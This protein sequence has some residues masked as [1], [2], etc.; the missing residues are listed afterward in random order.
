M[1][2]HNVRLIYARE[3]RDQLRDRRTLF[4]IAVLPLLLY[5]LLGMSV[6]QLSQF[7]RTSEPHVVI[8]G[9]E[10]IT[11]QNG[12]PALFKE[13]RFAPDLFDDPTDAERFVLDFEG[14]R[15]GA[16]EGSE[17]PT[18]VAQLDRTQRRLE[19]GEVDVALYFPA[20]FGRRLRE[21]HSAVESSGQPADGRSQASGRLAPNVN[22][23][24][25]PEILYNS[26]REKSRVAHSQVEQ[27]LDTWKSQIVR[28]NLLASRVPANIARPFELRPRDVAGRPEQQARVWSKILPFVLFIWALTGA[29]YPAVDLCAGEKERGTL[30]TLL[31]SP[32]LRGEI[33]WGKLLTVMTF[34]AATALLNLMSLGFTAR[35]VITQLRLIPTMGDMTAG[36]DLPPLA[37]TLWLLVALV[38][39]SALFSALC[40]ASAAFARSTKEGQYYLMP[41]LLVTMPLMMLPMAPGAE[42]NLGNSLIPV[43]GVVLLLKSLVQGNYT[44][45]LR[46]ALPVC[47]VTLACC[48]FAIRWAVYQ[49]NQETV[50]FRES[51]RF[52]LRRWVVHLVRDRQPTPSLAEA[53]FCVAIIYVV[54]FFVRLAV[55]SHMPASPEFSYL[56]LVLFISVVVCIALPA[57]LMTVILTGRPM[58]TL[59]L[60]RVPRPTA[61]VAAVL[62]AA[63]LHPVGQQLVTWIVQL[64]PIQGDAL[65]EFSQLIGAAPNFWATLLLLAAL[66]AICEELAFRGFILSGLRHLG[67]KWWAIGLTAVFFGFTHSVI[68][69]SLA[70]TVV[71]LVLGY[72]AV[73]TGSLIPCILFH[74]TYNSLGIAASRLPEFVERWPLLRALVQ[75]PAAGQTLYPWYVVAICAL[76]AMTILKWF[77]GLPY[78]ATREERISDARARQGQQPIVGGASH[79]ID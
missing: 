65:A 37:A 17:G 74:L 12:L 18:N 8:V 41:L 68:Q 54:Q 62:L 5:P 79:V 27:L 1:N 35:Y 70:A 77:H 36:L 78:P 6:F 63:A 11:D 40:L 55:S 33:V 73:Q 46:Y 59:L 66:P 4:M 15:N 10:Q 16:A 61:C 50:L 76:L 60:D 14:P 58:E 72:I 23:I 51:E 3:I 47:L 30:E 26:A 56:V 24:P 45:V 75:G 9:S 69:Q 52:D 39:M 22:D 43:T 2:W 38:P 32:A 67:Q 49:F 25:Q 34:S 48:H 13:G 71:G 28:E 31:S 53:F 64:Y 19:T 7:L 57:L 21:L 42:L 44:E 20:D 29:F